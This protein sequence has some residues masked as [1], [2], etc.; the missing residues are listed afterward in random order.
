M[1]PI[2]Q[3][4]LPRFL[5]VVLALIGTSL[6]SFPMMRQVPSASYTAVEEGGRLFPDIV[7]TP[8]VGVSLGEPQLILTNLVQIVPTSKNSV[9]VNAVVTVTH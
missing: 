6:P 2:G 8:V 1:H 3:S 9:E 4:I 7:F 5:L